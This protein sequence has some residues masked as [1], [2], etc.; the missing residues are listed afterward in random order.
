MAL[1]QSALLEVLDALRNADAADRITQA[2]IG[3]SS[4]IDT[5]LHAE[6]LP[7]RLARLDIPTHVVFGVLDQRVHPESLDAYADIPN[8]AIVRL[9]DA[10][11]TPPWESPDQMAEL[12]A[13]PPKP[14][15]HDQH[16]RPRAHQ[17]I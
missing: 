9:P 16:S 12:I 11:H 4:A 17:P 10:G 2:F 8:V 3:S 6:T 13:R 5:Y 15:Q 14:P 7:D 1:D